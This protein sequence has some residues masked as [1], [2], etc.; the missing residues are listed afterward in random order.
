MRLMASSSEASYCM[1]SRATR[2]TGV[3]MV[4][5]S[6]LCPALIETAIRASLI[7]LTTPIMPGH[8]T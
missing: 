5:A 3:P 8:A 4:V 1:I 7:P 6:S 2:A